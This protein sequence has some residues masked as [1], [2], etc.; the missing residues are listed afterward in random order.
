MKLFSTS[1]EKRVG[2][3]RQCVILSGFGPDL[4]EVPV[5]SPPQRS[6]VNNQLISKIF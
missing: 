5:L 2:K 3:Q 4:R 6:K 1:P